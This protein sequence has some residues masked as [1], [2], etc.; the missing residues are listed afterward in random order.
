MILSVNKIHEYCTFP[1]A[2][3]Y[4]YITNETRCI[5]NDNKVFQRLALYS[6][7]QEI[8]CV[9]SQMPWTDKY[10]FFREFHDTIVVLR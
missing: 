4:D 6:L 8:M 5:R 9:V 7:L 10:N 3:Q 1:I 2:N